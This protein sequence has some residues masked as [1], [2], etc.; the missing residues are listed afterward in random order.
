MNK[1]DLLESHKYLGNKNTIV[2]NFP[3][4]SDFKPFH[5]RAY[6][7][8]MDNNE[9]NQPAAS[10]IEM[11]EAHGIVVETVDVANENSIGVFTEPTIRWEKRTKTI[12]TPATIDDGLSSSDQILQWYVGY[13]NGT[14]CDRIEIQSNLNTMTWVPAAETSPVDCDYVLGSTGISQDINYRVV[15]DNGTIISLHYG[16]NVGETF[17]TSDGLYGPNDDN[18]N[19]SWKDNLLF[20]TSFGVT[21]GLD[22]GGWFINHYGDYGGTTGG[23]SNPT[24]L[25]WWDT[26]PEV[27]DILFLCRYGSQHCNRPR[28]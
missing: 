15:C 22:N 3:N 7:G 14:E 8:T 6:T 18:Y 2:D 19:D 24:Q 12:T 27:R 28:N 23:E 11:D 20:Q 4:M 16:N 25:E 26:L 1:K 13:G 17:V 5:A 21:N 10:R 9:T